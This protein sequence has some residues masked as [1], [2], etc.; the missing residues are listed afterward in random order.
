MLCVIE[1]H[2]RSTLVD[3]NVQEPVSWSLRR[4]NYLF[5]RCVVC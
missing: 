4:P 1:A 5:R 2:G 3:Q